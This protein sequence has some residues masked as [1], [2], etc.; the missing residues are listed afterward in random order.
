MIKQTRSLSI[1]FNYVIEGALKI[2]NTPVAIRRSLLVLAIGL[3]GMVVE[4]LVAVSLPW[5]SILIPNIALVLVVY[6]GFHDAT[7]LGVVLTFL[8]G[9]ITDLSSGYVLGRWAAGFLIVFGI[10][11]ALSQRLFVESGIAVV[12]ISGVGVLLANVVY[13]ALSIDSLP[14]SGRMIV[15]ILGEVL[16]TAL[17][18]PFLFRLFR[19]ALEPRARFSGSRMGGSSRTGSVMKR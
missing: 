1:K 9:T 12:V 4:S 11:S 10:I 5:A 17:L 3:T 14:D 6:L 13:G 16:A 7:I 8:L 15:S 19:Y 2:V 18:A